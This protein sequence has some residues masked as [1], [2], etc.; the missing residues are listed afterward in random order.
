M[1]SPTHRR[2]FTPVD[3]PLSIEAAVTYETVIGTFRHG[4]RLG[5]IKRDDFVVNIRV[6]VACATDKSEE[7]TAEDMTLRCRLARAN[8][9]ATSGFVLAPAPNPR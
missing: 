5:L 6:G 9:V 1:P 8:A 3:L 4:I 2:T 7:G